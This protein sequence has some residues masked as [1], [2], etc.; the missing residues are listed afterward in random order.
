M[1]QLVKFK[2]ESLLVNPVLKSNCKRFRK[3]D[4]RKSLNLEPHLELKKTIPRSDSTIL[5]NIRN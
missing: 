3:T 1:F 5:A 2:I 4:I